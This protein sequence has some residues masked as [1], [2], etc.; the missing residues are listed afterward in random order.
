MNVKEYINNFGLR[1]FLTKALRKPFY[2]NFS[3]FGIKICLIN[4]NVI[5]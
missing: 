3:H 2:N 4:E 1:I 5:T